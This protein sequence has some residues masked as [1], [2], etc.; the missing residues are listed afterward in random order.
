M[1]QKNIKNFV[2]SQVVYQTTLALRREGWETKCFWR[3]E[4]KNVRVMEDFRA[5]KKHVN[6]R[7]AN[8]REHYIGHRWDGS[9]EING[10]IFDIYI[11]NANGGYNRIHRML[12]FD[13]AVA[14][15]K[16][17]A[18]QEE[19]QIPTWKR[20]DLPQPFP[21][22][23]DDTS[24]FVGKTERRKDYRGYG[25]H[26]K[27]IEYLCITIETLV[28][29]VDC[30]G[31]VAIAGDCTVTLDAAV[32]PGNKA[33]FLLECYGTEGRFTIISDGDNY[34]PIRRMPDGGIKL[35]LDR[36]V[37]GVD[38]SRM[39]GRDAQNIRIALKHYSDWYAKQFK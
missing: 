8:R 11:R 34:Y 30:M 3:Q 17:I 29:S 20:D 25:P 2:D 16:E 21:L 4:S 22:P 31:V 10:W 23:F 18:A 36:K 38:I 28:H 24:V 13:D 6:L 26:N 19:P 39:T 12:N 7:G 14:K 35:S 1:A 15:A 37:R 33:W 9:P 5:N 27:K 32:V